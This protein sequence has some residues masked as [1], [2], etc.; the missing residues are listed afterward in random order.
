MKSY[1]DAFIQIQ[2]KSG[3]TG[4]IEIEKGVKQGCPLS[5]TLFNNGLDLL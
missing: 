4:K 3:T 5:P 1:K 2:T